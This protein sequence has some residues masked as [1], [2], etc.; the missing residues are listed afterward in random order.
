MLLAG[1]DGTALFGRF[2]DQFL[3]QRLDGAQVDHPGL[4]ALVLQLLGGNEGLVHFQAGGDDGHIAALG[5][6]FALADLELEGSFIMEH[7]QGQA[8]EA[9]VDGAFVLI[10]SLDGSLGLHVVGRAKHRHAGDGAH[11]G[12][13]LAALVRGAV[14][15]HRDAAV[16]GTDLDVQVGV[17]DGVADLLKGAAC[18]EH[19]KAGGKGH[20]PH[21]RHTGGGGHHV[22]LGNA[23]VKMAVGI[24]FFEDAGLGGGGQ[25][26]VQH[27]HVGVIFCQFY[28]RGAVAVAGGNFFDLTHTCASSSAS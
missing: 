26:G 15:A 19:G 28:Q 5:E 4:D 22:A 2:D 8:A 12:E 20:Q 14:L 6:L 3:V 24:G 1:D 13:I 7:W 18:G 17:A 21:S 9:Q 11:K 27:H 25:I 23:A 16:G 10:G